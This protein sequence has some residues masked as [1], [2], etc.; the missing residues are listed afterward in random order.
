MTTTEPKGVL[1]RQQT[2]HASFIRFFIDSHQWARKDLTNYKTPILLL[3]VA[4][5]LETVK[6]II[7][8]SSLLLKEFP[9]SLS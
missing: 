3:M 9:Y 1:R 7:L 2:R 6:S 8:S 5:I 4:M